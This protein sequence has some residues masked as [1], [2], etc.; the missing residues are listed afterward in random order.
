M[1]HPPAAPRNASKT[2]DADP[3]GYLRGALTFL[4]GG[5]ILVALVLA[6][7]G[8]SPRSLVLA[9]AL[10][11]LYG[12]A[13]GLLDGVIEPVVERLARA[14]TEVGLIR[15]ETGFS[16]EEALAIRG[17][18]DAAAEAYRERAREPGLR[19]RATV[20]RAML[21]AGPLGRPGLAVEELEAVRRDADRLPAE[22]DI[23]VGVALAGLYETSLADRGR[24]MGELRRLLDRHPGARQARSLRI[25][26]ANLRD[27]HFG[28]PPG[29]P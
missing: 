8:I 2:R 28:P 5:G 25:R 29:A 1:Q 18:A 16:M 10:W 23:A 11:A 17:H 6:A 9:G 22:D 24:A 7:T 19:A 26:L 15:R 13:S 27:D 20:R 12:A 3:F 4:F 14:L 21:L